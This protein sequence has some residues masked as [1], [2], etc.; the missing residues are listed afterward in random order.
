VSPHDA[1]SRSVE[2][3]LRRV[4]AMTDEE[5]AADPEWRASMAELRFLRFKA[6]LDSIPLVAQ[7]LGSGPWTSVAD[8]ASAPRIEA[9]R[10]LFDLGQR[11]QDLVA[12]QYGHINSRSH[13]DPKD[14]LA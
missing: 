6:A 9:A 5:L 14:D 12:G 13:T 4:S 10:R 8:T 7:A 2:A 1:V 11:A 3:E